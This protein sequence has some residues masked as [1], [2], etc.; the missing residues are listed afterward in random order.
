MRI[1]VINLKGGSGKTTL[2][3]NV[4]GELQTRGRNVELVDIDPQQSATLWAEH[5]GD[6][7]PVKVSSVGSGRDATRA[8]RVQAAIEAADE[9]VGRRGVVVIDCP[10][11]LGDN[12]MLACL[13]ADVVL[14][15]CTPSP[16]D[17]WAA[18]D[19]VDTVRD[20]R[21]TRKQRGKP[22]C[23]LVPS[24][25]P[26]GTLISRDLP[27]LL[28]GLGEPIAPAMTQRTAHV[29]ACVAGTSIDRYAPGSTAHADVQAV[30]DT[31]LAA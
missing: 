29:E 4:A 6:A 18:R 16:L 10:P 28:E 20:A 14:V 25:T 30:V 3:V 17:V 7:F 9:R 12:L 5:G 19:A 11:E 22:K 26:V 1:G 8:G 13:L 27:G 15:P 24:R 2:A 31:V 21:K 23:L